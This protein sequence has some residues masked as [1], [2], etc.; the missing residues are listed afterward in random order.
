MLLVLLLGV[1]DFGR[2]FAAGI[3]LE[4][5][6]RNAAEA[7]AQEYAQ[8]HRNKGSALTQADYDTLHARALEAAC[9]EADTLPNK[10]T[11]GSA[12]TMPTVAVCVHDQP[13]IPSDPL[14]PP[15]DLNC[16][17]EASSAPAECTQMGDAWTRN[18]DGGADRLAYV[19][20]RVCYEFTT[21]FSITHDVQLPFNWSLSIGEIW[22][23]RDRSFVVGEF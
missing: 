20:V 12:C 4:A 1:A 11:A 14:P 2:V 9:Q 6:A 13:A 8:I 7:A 22:L 21:L 15:G 18:K 17:T 10:A 5:M 23:Q 19:E 3:T 16:G